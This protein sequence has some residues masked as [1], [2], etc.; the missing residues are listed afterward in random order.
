MQK[1]QK[2]NKFHF[3]SIKKKKKLLILS[4]NYL[5]TQQNQFFKLIPHVTQA[6]ELQ[7]ICRN[8]KNKIY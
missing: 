4:S 3:F 8:I 7:N 5:L 6:A 1:V 2:I